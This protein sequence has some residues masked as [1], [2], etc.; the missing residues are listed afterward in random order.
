MLDYDVSEKAESYLEKHIKGS[1]GLCDY[2]RSC[3]CNLLVLYV[4]L[5]C[6]VAIYLI[7]TRYSVVV[8][9]TDDV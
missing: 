4:C 5:F 8:C 2:V 3:V 6:S 7:L 9:V 1:E